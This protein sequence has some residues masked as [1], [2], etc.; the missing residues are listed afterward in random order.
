[1]LD[2]RRSGILMPISS[3]PGPWGIGCFSRHAED[4]IDTLARAGQSIW[5]VLPFG[6]TGY[7]DS[8]YSSFSTFAGNHYFIDLDRLEAKGLLKASE[9]KEYTWGEDEE[10]V[11]YGALYTSRNAALRTAFRRSHD[12]TTHP[13]F[14]AFEEKNSAWLE[15]FALFMTA[16][17]VH[18]QAPWTTWPEG[19]RHRDPRALDELRNTH[20]EEITYQKWLQWV[21]D[22]QW[23]YLH[24][25]AARQGIRI[26]GDIPI[27]VA[28]DSADAW[29]HPEL[30]E[31]DENLHPQRVAGV[32][33]DGFSK[34]G[35][36]W[37]N[38]LYDWKRH[39]ESGYSWWIDRMRRQLDLVDVLRLDHFRG[40]ESYFAV[41]AGQD[42]SSNGVWEKG[43]GMELFDAL[44]TA[45]GPVPLV[46]EDLGYLTQE[47]ID[48]REASGYPGMQILQFAFDS[49]EPADYQPHRFP[50]D[51]VVYTG[52]H[53]NNTLIGW[54]D[55]LREEDRA[56]SRIYLNN[57]HTP[58]E[59]IPWD[60][61]TRAMTSVAR[62]CIVPMP[63]YLCLDASARINTP[64][65]PQGNWQWRMKEGAFTDKL[66]ERIHLLTL[67]SE[68]APRLP[69]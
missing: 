39:R 8:P 29:S 20:S 33:P 3:L 31:L 50:R 59:E 23:R 35:Q 27:Y 48:L 28:Q 60:F 56:L 55:T 9:L 19:L 68:R 5:Q 13:D 54:Y 69:S 2:T 40:L 41:P 38:P 32:P 44:H 52:T 1:M 15:D 30:F 47:V 53:D 66:A 64:A 42:T 63:D 46:L 43:P 4:F 18:N 26:L 58:T 57:A 21:F 36:V 7:G 14:V 25:R 61:I 37:G 49:R 62:T 16:K 65:F 6:P 24:E 67:A 22:T 51:T 11:D 10:R 45:L 34:T 12:V 17:G